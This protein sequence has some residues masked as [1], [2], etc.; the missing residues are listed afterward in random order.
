MQYLFHIFIVSAQTCMVTAGYNVVLGKGKILHFGQDAQSIVAV[1][2][3]WVL[4]AIHHVSFP[5]ALFVATIATL[6]VSAFLAWLSFRLEPDGYGVMSIAFHLAALSVVLNWQSVTRG[7][8]GISPI[9]RGPLPQSVEGFAAVAI[10]VALLWVLFLWW[11]DRGSF[12]RRL[13]ALSEQ[14]WYG[15]SLG[16]SRK[17]VHLIAF[18]LSGIGSLLSNIFHPAY[19][20][21]LNPLDYQFPSLIFLLTCIVAGGPGRVWGV[22]IATTILVALREGLRFVDLPTDVLGPLRLLLFGVILLAAV[23]WRRDTL[24]PKQRTI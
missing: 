11:L 22:A 13:S 16:I 17:R 8:L 14:L 5:A 6:V 3:F 24:F 21:L 20:Y 12:G 10:G 2:T 9:P 19:I 23:W 15:Q 1:Y 4:V 7:A 18:L